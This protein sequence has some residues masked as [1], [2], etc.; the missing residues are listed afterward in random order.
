M[1][2]EQSVQL[3]E[4][5]VKLVKV[6]L[7]HVSVV[8]LVHDLYQN[9]KRLLFRHFLPTNKIENGWY[10]INT[11]RDTYHEWPWSSKY[12]TCT[13]IVSANSEGVVESL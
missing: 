1:Y 9:G 11:V 3:V 8:V 6:G 4:H 5:E 10:I 12:Y 13:K 7:E 2:L